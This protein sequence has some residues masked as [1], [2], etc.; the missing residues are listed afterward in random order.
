MTYVRTVRTG[1]GAVAVQIAEKRWGRRIIV[2]HVGSAHNDE[3]LA[4]LKTTAR[5]RIEQLSGTW[6]WRSRLR[7]RSRSPSPW[8]RTG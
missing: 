4:V 3:E 1:S 7:S 2:E 6:A 8:S 5:A